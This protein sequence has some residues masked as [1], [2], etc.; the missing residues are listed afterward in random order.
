[1]VERERSAGGGRGTGPDERG[2]LH[3]LRVVETATLAAGPTVATALGEFGAEVI[4]VEPPRTG[5]PMRTW[6]D[7]KDGIGLVWKSI[8]R[9]K[10]CVTL[11][12]RRPAGQDLLHRLLATSDV[13]V[14]GTRPSTLERWGIDYASVH[15]AHP[16]IVFAH[17]S[18]YGAGG[19]KSDRPGYGTLAEAMSGFAQVT[20]QPDGPP[21]LPPFMLAD[22]VAGM[23]A[24]YAV[25]MALYHRDV[26]GGEGQLVDVSLIEP[27]SRLL[28]SSTLAYDQLGTVKGR[29]G[30]RLDASAPRNAYR[31][32]DGRWLAISSASPSIAVRVFRAIGRDDLAVHPDYVD[33]VRRQERALEVDGLV[34]DWVAQRTLDEAM[35]VFEAAQ[36]TAA[37]VYEAPQLLADEHLRARGMFLPVDDPDFG[38]VTVQAPVVR[39]SGT[40]GRVGHLGRPL[41]A[42]ND[43]VYGELL[44]LDPAEI[45]KLRTEGII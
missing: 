32:S 40:P 28:E 13:L 9:N 29:V 1:M 11:D 6:G 5:D 34:A 14:V 45:E 23:A 19:P 35:A 26:H 24:T 17:I 30:N 15:A 41:G 4:K 7:R 38:R 12:L 10:K 27:L 3:G 43:H 39:L 33:P 22:G 36:V 2:P 8:S 31:T 20:G 44:G 42:D 16:H 25:M 18:G 21:T 37:P